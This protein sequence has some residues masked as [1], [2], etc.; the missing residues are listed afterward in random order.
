MR[1][2]F[3]IWLLALCLSAG[4]QAQKVALKTNV[5]HWA[6]L[7]LNVEPEVIVGKKST[8]ALGISYNPWTFSE[9][10]KW[11]HLRVQPEYRYWICRPFGGH[12]L[13][14][15]ASYTRFN[16]G[17]VNLPFGIFPD[18]EKNRLQGNEWAVGLG[19]G[20]HW[21]LSSHW[22]MEAEVGL[23]FSHADFDRYQCQTCGDFL[24]S[25]H[26]NRFLPTKLAVS[27]VYVIR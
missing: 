17:N 12:F 9:N 26:T 21:I 19:Y 27:F 3:K 23:G 14:L 8:M 20:Y 5:F 6:T 10:R 22:S 16:V 4:A 11:R 2:R 18:L 25:K 24:N 15:H 7:S 13:G 1:S